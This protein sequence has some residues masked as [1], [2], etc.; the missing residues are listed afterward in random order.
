MGGASEENYVSTLD[1]FA[2]PVT[3]ALNSAF[4]VL[5]FSVGHMAFVGP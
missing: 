1:V 5:F 4:S 2:L 3:F